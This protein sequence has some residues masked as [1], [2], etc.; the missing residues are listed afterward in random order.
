[1]AKQRLHRAYLPYDISRY[2][3]LVTVDVIAVIVEDSKFRV[4]L[5]V[6]EYACSRRWESQSGV[7][8]GT[9]SRVKRCYLFHPIPL[10]VW[11]LA[12]YAVVSDNRA[13]P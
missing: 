5:G 4:Y 10:F 8:F 12:V 2:H 11:T 7:D 6:S 9:P 3:I 13:N 1:M